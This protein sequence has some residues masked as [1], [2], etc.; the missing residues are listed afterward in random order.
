MQVDCRTGGSGCHTGQEMGVF[1]GRAK[2]YLKELQLDRSVKGRFCH[3]CQD[4]LSCAVN[5]IVG[6]SGQY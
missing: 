6:N 3:S 4:Q 1:V 2:D 5:F